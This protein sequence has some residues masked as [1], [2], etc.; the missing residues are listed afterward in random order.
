MEALSKLIDKAVLK[1]FLTG[2][3]F[4]SRGGEEV[5]V[6]HLLYVDNMLI[7][8]K[9]S[10]NEMSFLSWTLMWFEVIFGLR[11]NLEKSALFLVGEVADVEVL[12]LELGCKVGSLPTS[13]LGLPLGSPHKSVVAWDG[14]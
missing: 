8:C 6:S 5:V 3:R 12:A 7:F 11:I 13:Y 2:Y 1:R 9:D 14:V 10:C 4:K